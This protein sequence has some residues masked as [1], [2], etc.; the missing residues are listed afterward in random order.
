MHLR[1]TVSLLAALGLLAQAAALERHNRAM[2]GVSLLAELSADL[3]RTCHG[4]TEKGPLRP[5]ENVDRACPICSSLGPALLAL[6]SPQDVRA[7]AGALAVPGLKAAAAAP[8]LGLLLR[9]P[10]R[11]PPLRSA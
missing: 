11:A 5:P 1:R 8:G 3:A 6:A 7:R 4:G 10:V 2:L 9:P